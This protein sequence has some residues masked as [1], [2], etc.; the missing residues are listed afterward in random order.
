M[1]RLHCGP[2]KTDT[3]WLALTCIQERLLALEDKVFHL[4]KKNQKTK[5]KKKTQPN[6]PK[7]KETNKQ[8]NLLKG[9]KIK[10]AL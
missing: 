6:K 3:E 1:K 7:T 4:G 5:N 9:G 10:V 8:K 2:E